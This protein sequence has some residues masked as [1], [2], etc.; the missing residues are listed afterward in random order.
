MKKLTALLPCLCLAVPLARAQEAMP[1]VKEPKAQA[2]AAVPAE[3]PKAAPAK[4]SAAKKAEPGAAKKAEAK[5]EEKPKGGWSADTWSGLELRS[6]GPAVSSGRVVDIAVDP[7]DTS[8]FFLAVASGGVW[9]TENGGTTWTPV[10]DGEGSYSIGCVTID[11]TNPNVVWVGTG[12]N[13]AQ[14]SVGYG[15]GVYKS[16]DGGRSWKNVGLKASEHIGKILVHPKDPNIVYVAAQGPLWAPGGDRGLYKTTDG[17]RTWTAVLT[18]D[19]NTGVTDVVMDPRDPDTLLAA[20]W[21]R[22]RHVFTLIDGGPGSGLHKTT[23]GGKTWRTIT[24]GLPKEEMGRIGLALA[25]TDPDTVYALVETAAAN[26]AGGTFRSRNRGE[27]WEKQGDYVPGGP[28]YYQEIFVDPKNAERVYSM[29]VFLKVSDDAGKTWRNLGERYKHV[30]NHALW[31]DPADT[32]HYLVGCDGGLYESRDRAATWRFFDNLPVTQFYRVDVDDSSPVYYVYGG[33]QDNNTLGGP[34]RTLNAHGIANHDWFVTWGGDGFHARVDPRDPNIVY[35]TLQYGVLARYDRKSGEAVLIQPQEKPGDDPLRWNWDSPLV[36]SPHQPT[37]LYFAAQRVFRSEDRG[38]TWTAVSGDLTRRIDRNTLK[39]MGK[40]WGP[41]AVAKGASTSFYGNVVSLDESPL[42][43][44]LLYVG[45]DDGLVQVSEDGGRTWRRQESFPGVPAMSYV[46]D[47]FASRFDANV[48]YAAFDDHKTGDFKPYLLRSGDRGR[49]WAPVAG[50]LPVRGNVWTVA[51]DTVEKELLFAG[52]EFGL[53]FSRDGGRKWVQ[54]KGGLPTI[55]VH[56]LKVQRRE[57]D[58]VVATFGRGFYVLDDLTPLRVA[59]P[60]DLE[61]DTLAFPVKRALAYVPSTPLG[62]KEKAFLGETFFTAKNPPFGAVF[63]YYLKDE[64]E[65]RRK[66]RLDAEK[67]AEKKGAEIQYPAAAALRAEAREEDPAVVLTV[68]DEGGD[69]VRRLTG[70]VKAGVHRVAWDLRFPASAP[71]SLKPG[72]TPTEN[73]FYEPPA[74]P[75][76]VPGRYTVSF[77]KRV[78]GVLTPFGEP[79]PFT[80]ESLGLQTLKARDAA[81]LLAFERKTARLQRAVLGAVEAAEEAQSR[82]KVAKKALDDTPGAAPALGAE[83]RRIEKALDDL[84][85][86]LRGDKVLR[87]RNEPTALSTVERVEAIVGTHWSAT[88]APTGTSREAYAV[89]SSAFEAQLAALRTLVE[90]DLR[91]LE[92]AMEKAGAP[93]TPGRVPTWT[94]E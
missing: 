25:P 83:A 68:K 11:P 18:V 49:T 45:T 15:D 85:V 34:S 13:N 41:D 90:T 19:E 73:P 70:P 51:E 55:A 29:D 82:V 80:V 77:E 33:T 63:T 78:D 79:Q 59:K 53:F 89:A 40:V 3:A 72:P 5:D 6:L 35:S 58:L 86:G 30:D 94:K 22:R 8:R 36:L 57:G 14:R 76:A 9:K 10:F 44:G 81:E 43:E 24:T 88:V 69:V 2:A 17:G 26:K 66:A 46:S 20:A 74:G 37:R 56:D 27:T 7:A 23:D 32:D 28:M 4:A 60:A 21:Q 75:L 54:L 52:T 31:I 62:L 38:D 47:L 1:P 64:L 39:V 65:T 67:E 91:A 87:E 16:E 93:W 92:G 61:R 84:M 12:E 50:D 42:V 48:V 71:T